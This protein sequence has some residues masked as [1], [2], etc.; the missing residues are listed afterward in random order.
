MKGPNPNVTKLS[1]EFGDYLLSMVCRRCKHTRT[2]EPHALARVF[3]WNTELAAIAKRLRCSRCH[4]RDC[5]LIATV[6]PRPRGIPKNP[7]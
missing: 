6:R 5:E 4:A 3:G 1:D 7:H 2:T